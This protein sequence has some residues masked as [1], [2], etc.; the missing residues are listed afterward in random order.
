MPPND[1]A[2]EAPL[3]HVYKALP[4]DSA[5]KHVQGAAEYVDDIPEPA[6]TLHVALGGS[7]VARG[8]IRGV[9][10]AEVQSAPGVVAVV[11]AADIP[12]KND[13]AP[14][15]A[16]EPVFARDRVIFHGQPVFAVVAASRDAARRA[17]LRARFNIEA[18]R[19][20]VSVEQGKT[21]GERVLPDYAFIH[22]DAAK[23]IA[24]ATRSSPAR[25]ASAARNT[26]ISKARSRSP[27]RA[28]TAPCWSTRS[29][30]H[31]T[32]VQHIVAH[33]LGA[34]RC[35]RHRATC[36]AWAAAS[37]AR[38]RQATQ[39]AALAALAARVTGRPCKLRL[40]RD[41]DMI[42]TGKRHDFA[43][44]YD[45]GFDNDGALRAV[46][47]ELAPRCGYSADLSLGVDRP[48]DVPCRQRLFLPELHD[49]LAAD[50]R[51]IPSRTPPSAA[52]AVRRA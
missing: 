17:A 37:A 11:T 47:V 26:S 2:L 32:E 4:H 3:R 40:D 41:D 30:Q 50:A 24:A 6:G 14:A 36:A 19:P 29:T 12:G 5:A 23:A 13:V 46:D 44:D 28:R 18:E 39:W 31:P 20:N 34:A 49:P 10:L 21:S 51:P 45:V 16:D 35:T 8:T 42:M 1:A 27:C 15:F 25:S 38:K 48:G 43:V 52:S 22:G 33:V 9:D 7:P